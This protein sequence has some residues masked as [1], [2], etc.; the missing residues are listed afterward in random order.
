MVNSWV[1]ELRELHDSNF[2]FDWDSHVQALNEQLQLHGLDEFGLAAPG[3]PP[4]W[5][6][7]NVEALAPDGWVLVVSLNQA[8]RERDGAWHLAQQ[9]TSQSYWDHWR[10]LNRD[11]WEPRFYRPL[12]RLASTALGVAVDSEMEFATT[13]MVFVE[14]CP[15]ASRRFQLEQEKLQALAQ[16]DRGFE[17]AARVRRLLIEEAAPALVMVNGVA[18]LVDFERFHAAEVQTRE[19]RY[20]SVS[21]PLRELWHVEGHYRA[22]GGHSVPVLGFPFLRNPQTHNSYAEIE[23]LGVMAHALM[24]R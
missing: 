9:Y 6:V 22:A 3:L 7:G 17:L 8:R 1:H 18:A 13:R 11:W 12:V 14:L 20:P 24:H 16:E 23:Q 2:G 4:V 21:R 15:Y 19:R 5:F 10:W